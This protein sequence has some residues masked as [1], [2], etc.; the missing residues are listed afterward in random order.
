M[1][2][3]VEIGMIGIG[4]M[5]WV[6]ASHLL[7]LER[8]GA[9]KLRA[10][11]DKNPARLARFAVE[12]GYSGVTFTSI[13]EYLAAGL[14]RATMVAT[15]TE[16][17]GA[18]GM[19]LVKAGHRVLL[20]KPL[21][22][23]L[24]GDEAC[25]AELDRDYPNSLML[26]F[27]RRYD[28]AL[29]Y[30]RE[31]MQQGAIGRVFKIYSALED[32]GPPPDGYQSDGIL[33]DMS[34]HNVDEILWLTGSIPDRALV[35]GSVLHNKHVASC[36]E[37]FDDAMLYLWFGTEMLGQVQVTR[38]HVSGYRVETSIYGDQGQIQI[39]RFEQKPNEIVVEAFGKRGKSEPIA[40]KVFPG[41]KSEP[42]AP[43]FVDRF[44][45]AYKAEAAAFIEC[46][47]LGTAFPTSHRDGLRAQRVIASGMRSIHTRDDA[48]PVI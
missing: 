34:V 10:V 17:H 28:G 46:C 2:G 6:H 29:S 15:P 25:C 36:K 23:T 43:E 9:C 38:N 41:G 33:P 30:G 31:L 7:E 4:R 19:A 16:F 47:R 22:G 26:A 27:Q 1:G 42:N 40:R 14:C 3:Q 12:T 48:A 39:G 13:E 20:E 11:V 37:D 35:I 24:A 5:G 18:H 44:G 45:P 8:E 21:T 32:S